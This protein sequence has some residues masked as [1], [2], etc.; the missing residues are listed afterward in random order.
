MWTRDDGGPAGAG[1]AEPR[2][3]VPTASFPL[4][5]PQLFSDAI[6]LAVSYKQNSR[7]FMDEVLQELEVGP[8]QMSGGI[9]RTAFLCRGAEL[10]P[11]TRL[12]R[13]H[14][15]VGVAPGGV[16]ASPGH[17]QGQASPAACS[18]NIDLKREEEEEEE[19]QMPDK[20]QPGCQQSPSPS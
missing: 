16:R 9:E 7:D 13:Q 20:E 5:L 12:G 2:P 3:V 17:T 1:Q 18:Q 4:P 15:L 14:L 8:V 19:E 10:A 11:Q 6:R